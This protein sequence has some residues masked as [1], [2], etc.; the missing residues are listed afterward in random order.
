MHQLD[1]GRIQD[2][3][4]PVNTREVRV[5]Y[6]Y[7]VSGHPLQFLRALCLCVERLGPCSFKFSSACAWNVSAHAC[8]IHMPHANR[9][10]RPASPGQPIRSSVRRFVETTRRPPCDRPTTIRHL[11][12]MPKRGDMLLIFF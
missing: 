1:T 4:Y 9:P 7:P 3:H 12:S 11:W 8:F 6:G 10:S 2:D 5:G